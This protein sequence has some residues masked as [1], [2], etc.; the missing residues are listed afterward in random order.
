MTLKE[1]AD[2]AQMDLVKKVLREKGNIEAAA[3]SVGV[4]APTLYR[5]LKDWNLYQGNRLKIGTLIF[6]LENNFPRET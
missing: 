5:K 4:S 3:K 1:A 2:Q 6:K